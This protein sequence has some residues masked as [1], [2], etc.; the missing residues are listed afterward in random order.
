MLPNRRIPSTATAPDAPRTGTGR[1]EETDRADHVTPRK[2]AAAHGTCRRGRGDGDLRAECDLCPAVARALR[3]SDADGVA[4]DVGGAGDSAFAADAYG[5]GGIP[6]TKP[7]GV[8][9][10]PNSVA[11]VAHPMPAA[12]W[13]TSRFTESVYT[14]PGLTP[15]VTY[16]LRLYFMDRYLTRPGQRVFAVAVNGATVLKDFDMIGAAV[17]HGA[18]DQEAFGVEKDILVTVPDSGTVTVGFVRG[19]ANQPQVDAPALMPAGS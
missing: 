12:L 11:T 10:L 13:N 16:E 19:A 5:T 8:A 14:M 15:G 6:D 7:A 9:S 4:I 3:G 17:T 2:R 1:E 18:D